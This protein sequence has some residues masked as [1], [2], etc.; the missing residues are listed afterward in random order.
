MS[1]PPCPRPPAEDARPRVGMQQRQEHRQR[2][3][4][5]ADG[6][7]RGPDGAG[8]HGER[9]RVGRRFAAERPAPA[10]QLLVDL[11]E[12]H[13]QEAA[14][15]EREDPPGHAAAQHAHRDAVDRSAAAA[16][17]A[18]P[19][20]ACRPGSRPGAGRP[21]RRR[22]GAGRPRRRRATA[23]ARRSAGRVQRVGE[24]VLQAFPG[25][26]D[27]DRRAAEHDA[28]E[29]AAR[30]DLAAARPS[31]AA[32]RAQRATAPVPAMTAPSTSRGPR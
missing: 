17:P 25:R 15:G 18:A 4:H 24:A 14:G 1:S 23:P 21:D 31:G 30:H 3:G 27:R 32:S 19:G 29:R 7:G 11:E 20:A 12:Q 28:G 22:S 26:P 5:A 13:Q 16:R 10:G 2:G 6:P 9:R 8:A